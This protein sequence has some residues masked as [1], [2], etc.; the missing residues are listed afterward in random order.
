MTASEILAR[1]EE[2]GIEIGEYQKG[3]LI[4]DGE[5]ETFRSTKIGKS[6][7]VIVEEKSR[8]DLIAEKAFKLSKVRESMIDLAKSSDIKLGEAFFATADTNAVKESLDEA[9][10]HYAEL[11]AEETALVEW[12]EANKHHSMW[13]RTDFRTYYGGRPTL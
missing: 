7:G 1:A 4:K 12:L 10:T 5:K 13:E 11:K 2:M 6:Y 8:T 9:N 3:I